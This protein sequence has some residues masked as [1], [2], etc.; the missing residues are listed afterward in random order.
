VI[1]RGPPRGGWR[2]RVLDAHDG[3]PVAGARVAITGPAFG[4]GGRAA[5]T[6][7]DDEGRF[8]LPHVDGANAEGAQIETTARWHARLAR[9]LPIPGYVAIHLV[10][11][12][13][14]L[15]ERLVEWARRRGRPWADAG[16]PTPGHVVRV[17]KDRRAR[18][19]EGWAKAVERAAYG[20]E[21]PDEGAEAEVRERE[22]D[23][24]R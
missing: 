16:E 13:R 7:T 10:S 20:P 11:R 4:G 17:A 18:D 22:P 15:L 12:R 24:R 1:E 2:G 3:A 5:T 8:E 9:P 19:V 14:A 6:T 23:W 21:P